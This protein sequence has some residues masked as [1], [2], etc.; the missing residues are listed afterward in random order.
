MP[1]AEEG[2]TIAQAVATWN[3]EESRRQ[4][5]EADRLRREFVEQFPID[6]W[7]D[8]P[9][10]SYALGREVEGG[11]YCWW[12]EFKTRLVGSMSGGSA[13]K[14]LI[15][16][17][18][19]QGV[20][21]YP[22]EY[23]SVEDAWTAVH[24]GFEQIL[25]LASEGRFDETDEVVA[26]STAAAL[27]LKTL[28]MYFP[29][30]LLPISSRNHL[31]RYL[32]E[33]GEPATG[34]APVR[35]NRRLLELLG[36]R[37]E[38][39][40]LSP[41]EVGIF[42]YHW[43]DPRTTT[44]IMK[45]APGEQ[46]MYWGE[47]LAGSYICVG[48]DD[49]GDLSL[50][51]DKDA[52]REAFEEHYP[53]N[54]NQA[55][56][57]R[58]ANEL[59]TLMEL[60]PGDKI[61]ANKGTSQVLAI[62]TVTDAGYS[63]RPDREQYRHTVTVEWDTSVGRRIEPVRAWATTTVAKVG[64]A[65]YRS[66]LGGDKPVAAPPPVDDLYIEIERSV[67]RRGQV[68][69]YGPPGTGKTY[70]A[71]RAAVWLLDGGSASTA[72]G[73]LLADEQRFKQ[74]ERDFARTADPSHNTWFMVANP[75]QWRWSN[76]DV[77]GTVDYSY[78]QL[79]R[80]YPR[81]RAGDLVVGYE[82]SPTQRVVALARVTGEY[83]PAGPSMQALILEPVA[84]V[85]EG[86]TWGELQTDEVLATSEPVRFRCRGSLFALSTVE[87]DYLLGRLAQ[88]DPSVT[89]Y[90]D[91]TVQ[92]LT[93][94]TFHPS[95]TYEDFVEGFRPQQ[96][97]AGGGLELT[98]TDGVFKQVCATASTDPDREYVIVIDEINRGNMPKVFGELISLIEKDKRGL[99]VRLPQSGEDFAVPLNVSIIATMNTA[100]RSIHLLDTALRRR[101]AFVE[102]LPDPGVL[103]G[104]TVGALALDV[105][106][107]TLNARVGST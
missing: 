22:K 23:G 73:Q 6:R 4:A 105:F 65:L 53:Y 85:K 63:W 92:R 72:A 81:V 18:R 8:L 107:E 44:R 93:R 76:L 50:Y 61:I 97:G 83:D 37:P 49:V 68:I 95:Y 62:G 31:Q 55:Q 86:L 94:V 14:H 67:R 7:G 106:L 77:E 34:L 84:P 27:R 38:L 30:E 35:A 70:A 19:N 45:I 41:Q 90:A 40:D 42:L 102:L 69:L 3:R 91:T 78:G 10:E 99:K 33:L 13:R 88:R 96:S 43:L 47:C 46:A 89:P 82:S 79:H 60:E 16:W 71:R 103:T 25:D 57:S 9:L 104:A 1:E 51:E 59:W 75:A 80:N 101:F 2:Q 48:W 11:S 52:F 36:D 5:A 20:W 39:A 56:I 24:H 66:I 98:M 32:S 12:L 100:D 21:R 29:D 26:L 54:G 58:K 17:A 64:P 87:A 28:Y 15:W 74:R